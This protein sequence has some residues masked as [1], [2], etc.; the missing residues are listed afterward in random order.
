M[1]LD[2]FK[3]IHK[4]LTSHLIYPVFEHWCSVI[5]EDDFMFTEKEVE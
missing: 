5:R 4:V 3:H 1:Y 2:D